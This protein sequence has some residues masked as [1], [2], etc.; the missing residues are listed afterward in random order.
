MD[1]ALGRR[2]YRVDGCLLFDDAGQELGLWSWNAAAIAELMAAT[3]TAIQN[4]KAVLPKWVDELLPRLGVRPDAWVPRMGG[5]GTISGI[6]LGSL[7]S[8]RRAS[9]E[10]RMARDKSGLFAGGIDL[11]QGGVAPLKMS[12]EH[13]DARRGEAERARPFRLRGQG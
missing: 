4:P 7:A 3:A 6:V 8:Q 2:L 13:S 9:P 11:K 5:G 12:S 10:S 1:A